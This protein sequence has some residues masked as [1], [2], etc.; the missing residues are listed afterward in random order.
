MTPFKVTKTLTINKPAAELYQYW[1]DF[2]NL[3]RFMKHLQ[4]VQVL[5][6]VKSHWTTRGPLGGNV[7]WDAIIVEDWENQSIAWT[8]VEG[9]DVASTT[10]PQARSAMPYYTYSANPPNSNSVTISVASK[11]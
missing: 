9:A 7:E 5:D 3:P 10:H 1:H 2:E 6:R 11:C 4:S 8:S